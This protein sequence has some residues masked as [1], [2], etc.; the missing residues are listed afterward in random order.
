MNKKLYILLSVSLLFGAIGWIF[1]RGFSTIILLIPI[2]VLFA[3]LFGWILPNILKQ[4]NSKVWLAIGLLIFLGLI[5]PT[6]LLFADR[7]PGPVSSLIGT[8]LY[9]LPS[10]A[11]VVSA[12]ILHAG[13][14]ENPSVSG[15]K[16]TV[17]IAL[18]L[19][20]VLV[21]K[22]LFNLYE[23]TVW[24]N[25]DDGLGYLWLFVPIF[26]AL[27]SGVMLF[28]LLPNRTKLA[29]FAY[30]LLIPALMIAVSA[31]AQRVD[32]RQETAKRAER[33]VRAIES[34]YVREGS[35]PETL[36][37]LSPWYALSL[38]KPV[39][40]YGQDWCYESSDDYYSL[41]YVD[42]EHW[43]DPRL[44]GR[45]YKSVGEL[46]DSQPMCRDEV[47]AIQSRF[48]DYQYS[49]WKESE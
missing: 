49:Y 13:L 48:P 26:F 42:R 40:I 5:F 41:G 44:I 22:V 28:V 21:V 25:T 8:T 33:T 23:F 3:G 17:L 12:M 46:P 1:L 4:V 29:G 39:I 47:E 11:L 16:K 37:Q 20:I 14:S 2:M 9:F 27:L 24:D 43:S 15:N 32:F 30:F 36:S 38:P 18:V 19:C 10:L 31:I 6:S 35:Y 34:Y 7:E 45:I